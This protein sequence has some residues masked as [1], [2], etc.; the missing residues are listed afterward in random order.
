ME[1]SEM[2]NGLELL[3]KYSGHAIFGQVF[4]ADRHET[5]AAA[6]TSENAP[7]SACLLTTLKRRR[8]RIFYLIISLLRTEYSNLAKCHKEGLRIIRSRRRNCV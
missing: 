5:I 8:Q 2:E 7:F 1:K 6:A 4:M 3:E